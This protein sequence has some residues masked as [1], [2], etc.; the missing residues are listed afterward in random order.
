MKEEQQTMYLNVYS[1]NGDILVHNF[2]TTDLQCIEA[3][4]RVKTNQDFVIK[5]NDKKGIV[6]IPKEVANS[7][8]YILKTDFSRHL[9]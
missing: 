4:N 6:Y 2:P 3:M 8:I 7:L 9:C 5:D 1:V